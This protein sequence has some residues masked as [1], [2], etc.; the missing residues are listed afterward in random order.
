MRVVYAVGA[1]MII[2]AIIFMLFIWSLL[3]I[4]SKPTPKING[5]GGIENIWMLS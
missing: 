1:L 2:L 4:A 5:R 3:R